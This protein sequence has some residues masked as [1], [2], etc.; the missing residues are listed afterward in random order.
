[1]LYTSTIYDVA[2]NVKYLLNLNTYSLLPSNHLKTS[3]FRLG[4]I[5]NEDSTR[6][7]IITTDVEIRKHKCKK[8][9]LPHFFGNNVASSFL[10]NDQ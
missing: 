1:M 8:L 7:D 4:K 3:E 5:Q 10:P 2:G 9:F 6:D